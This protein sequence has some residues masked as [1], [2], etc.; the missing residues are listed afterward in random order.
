MPAIVKVNVQL[1]QAPTPST[2]QSTGAILSQGGTVTS[3]GTMTLLTQP[4]SLTPVLRG[5]LAI[6]GIV[7]TAGLATATT[8]AHGFT[9]GDTLLLLISGATPVAYNGIQNVTITTTTAFTFAVPSGT[10]TPATGTM[11]YTPE[12]VAELVSQVSTYFGQ[13]GNTAVYVL[14]L[15]P[16]N[17][18]DGVAFLDT[19][20]Q[21]N[22]N[23]IAYGNGFY[24]FYGYLV[25]REWDG[26][27]NFLA[28]LA[29]FE[30]PNA[31]TYFW[32]TTTLATYGKY[33]AL[34]KCVI[35]LIES[36]VMGAYPANALTAI[37]YSSG[38]VTAATTTAHGITPGTWFQIAGVTPSGY[39]GWWQ[40][41][42]G[43]T[44]TALI[45]NSGT[46][47]GSETVLGTLVGN[48][49][50][51]AGT[52][53]TEFSL[54]AAF[55]VAMS[56]NPS[57]LVPPFSYSFLFGVTPFPQ[58]GTSALQTTLYNANI[59]IVGTGAE[60]GISDAILVNG[61][62]LD[63]NAYNFWYAIDWASINI[64]LN[65]SNAVIN[66]SNTSL[67]PLYLNQ[68]GINTLQG[69]GAATISAGISA[70][71]IFGS[72]IQTELSGPAFAAAIA[73][74]TYNGYAVINA[75]PF[76]I[77]YTNNPGQYKTRTYQGYAVSFAPQN[78]FEN[79]TFNLNATTFVG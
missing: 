79:I 18:N 3:P 27:G 64:N 74:G 49:Y 22:P 59:S 46:A 14:E 73:A 13:G 75:I 71:L 17:T 66:G 23:G 2:L 24:G 47:L 54:A 76:P 39:N 56:I 38:A 45:Y 6:T 9:V 57:A 51:N 10:T 11:V 34:M 48:L 78:G 12:D 72:L 55:N 19:W 58:L 32:V 28:L 70:G 15:G 4:S 42:A 36:P 63:G 29:K 33:T 43:T 40:A 41:Q 30:S 61:H 16:G 37:A 44:G 8:P 60:G 52:P 53:S 77:Y 62:T 68:P 1:T 65:I 69:V 21:N 31:Q 5:A 67:A 50:S 7:Q 20:I 35:P 25:P 26:N